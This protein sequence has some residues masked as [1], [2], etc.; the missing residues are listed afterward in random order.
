MAV[1]PTTAMAALLATFALPLHAFGAGCKIAEV[2]ELPVTMSGTRPLVAAKING[3]D[4]QFVADS[5]A[6]YSIIGTASAAEYDLQTVPGPIDLDVVG[7]GG[8]ARASL[9]TVKEFTLAGAPIRNV[10]F[11]VGGGEPGRGAVGVLGQNVW[12]VGD[13]EYDLANGR[14]RIMRPQDCGKMPMVYWAKD[15]DMYSVMSIEHATARQPHTTG[16][17]YLN[18]KKIRVLFDTGA[19]A[20]M[21]SLRAAAA[22][23]VETDSPSATKAGVWRGIGSRVMQTW[24]APFETFKI[25]DE[26]IRNTKLR[27]GELGGDLDML[28]G[29][30]FFLSHRVYVASSQSKL[31]F[32]YNGGPVF[33]LAAAAPAEGSTTTAEVPRDAGDTPAADASAEANADTPTDA[34]GFSRR[35]TAFAARRD[36]ER[37]IADLTRACELAPDE[38]DYF[39]QRANAYL[40][41]RRLEPALS[42]LERTIELK[43][44]HVPALVAR[45]TL[46]LLRGEARG[47]EVR[48]DA[49]ADLRKAS[50]AADEDDDIHL[51]IASLYGRADDGAAA[52]SELDLWLDKHG[53]DSRAPNARANRCRARAL[54]DQDLKDALADCN[55]AVR[56]RS[57]VPYFHEARGL[58]Y[59]RMGT[60]DKAVADYDAALRTQPRNAWALYG[61]GI[62]RLRE[63]MAEQGQA[64]IAA[65]RRFAPAAVALAT[66]HGI[67]P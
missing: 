4:A 56:A 46:R 33:N 29:A 51:E 23:G 40:G 32:T 27:F 25:G 28:V 55:R 20:S 36:F 53:E 16:V 8:R 65:A 10:Q 18:G 30:D 35:G 3:R 39:F 11:I 37:A 57:D 12:R 54:L 13:V 9:T 41:A 50:T 64:D 42:D 49:V 62:A 31:Y 66:R 63:G 67:T 58:V 59:L 14:I 17:A 5:G 34:A 7:I 52:I 19:S 43:P 60:Y 24:I 48:A 2:A 15:G 61:R 6:F 47:G 22:A 26:E 38:P 1:R 21:L 44:D 45:A